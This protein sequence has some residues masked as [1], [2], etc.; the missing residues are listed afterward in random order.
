MPRGKSYRRSEAAKMRMAERRTVAF[1]PQ[2]SGTASSA[3]R[4]TGYRHTVLDWPISPFT[5][6]KHKLVI[7]AKSPDKKFVL[8]VGASHLRA[9]VDGFVKMPEGG[10]SFGAMSTPG[11]CAAVLRTEVVHT[12]L[13]RTPDAVCVMAPSNNLT[14]S[15][16]IEEAGADFG[17]LLA[18]VSE[19]CPNVFVL[20]FP[21][22]LNVE[23]AQQDFMRQE[24]RRVAA[25]MGMKYYSMVEYFPLHRLDLWAGDGIHLSD[26]GGMEILVDVLWGAAYKQLCCPAPA[27][28]PQVSP[29]PSPP[30]FTPTVVV[31]GEVKVPRR[32]NPYDWTL[33]GQGG[34]RS[35]PGLLEPSHGAPRKRM[36]QQQ[37]VLRDCFIPLTPVR[38]SSA[39]LDAMDKLVPS[40]LPSPVEGTVPQPKKKPTVGHQ[41]RAAASQRTLAKRQVEAATSFVE[42]PSRIAST[43]SLQAVVP[44][45]VKATPS[46]EVSARRSPAVPEPEPEPEPEEMP[47]TGVRMR[48]TPRSVKGKSDGVENAKTDHYR[49]VKGSFHQGD[50]RFGKNAGT[51]CVAMSLAAMIMHEGKNVVTWTSQLLD[52]LESQVTARIIEKVLELKEPLEFK[53]QPQMGETESTK[54]VLKM[55]PTSDK[56]GVFHDFFHFLEA[57]LLKMVETM[58]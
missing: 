11:A 14:S 20:D 27:P 46:V 55:E 53:V 13:P 34:K 28:A 39:M 41:Q 24:F 1:P 17:K 19:R 10:L 58:L 37:A 50:V 18:T 22:R 15:R 32:L 38:F 43:S 30:R 57:F 42:V 45:E 33:V 2:Q 52:K 6:R 21:P 47:E 56:T 31:K 35:Q 26:R 25:R 4:G 36:V 7:P 5:G 40:H 12:V 3:R 54:A 23:V 44:D 9:I 48:R 16:T 49:F 29:R 51:Q 8:L